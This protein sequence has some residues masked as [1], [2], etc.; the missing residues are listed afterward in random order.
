[1]KYLLCFDASDCADA[2]L[3][4]LAAMVRPTDEVLVFGA[5][6]VAKSKLSD[7][8]LSYGTPETHVTQRTLRKRLYN[9]LVAAGDRLVEAAKL[10]TKVVP[11]LLTTSDIRASVLKVAEEE[12]VDTIVVGTR[13]HS[14]LKRVLVG[15]LTD[16]LVT[17]SPVPVVVVRGSTKAGDRTVAEAEAEAAEKK[18]LQVELGN[19]EWDSRV[20]VENF[21]LLYDPTAKVG[22]EKESAN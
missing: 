20:S 9:R 17:H 19:E 12:K 13:G 3:R 11:V 18:G 2:A 8:G 14:G 7:I 21:D 22:I 16:Y 15:S 5:T 10:E 4:H 1:M 6:E